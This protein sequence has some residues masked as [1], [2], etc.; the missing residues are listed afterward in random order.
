MELANGNKTVVI[1]Y[2][3]RGDEVGDT[4]RAAKT[5]KDNLVRMERL[6]AEQKAVEERAAAERKSTM[7]MLAN[8]FEGTVGGIVR[9]VFSA[10]SGLEDAANM[11]TKTAE[12]TE[13]LSS[14]VATASERGLHQRP[15]RRLRRR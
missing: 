9:T 2:A 8:E 14:L 15:F 3:T 7:H 5:F 10:S 12:T 1:P 6:E 11:L 4:A 13:Q